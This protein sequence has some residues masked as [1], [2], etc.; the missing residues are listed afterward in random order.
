[1]SSIHHRQVK[2]VDV[3][4]EHELR[5]EDGGLV[6]RVQLPELA[7]LENAELDISEEKLSL[8]VP[9]RYLLHLSWP[10]PIDTDAAKAKFLKKSRETSET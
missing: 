1:M 8:R 9:S 5:E 7:S 6:L 2:Y 4:P 10:Q 3:E